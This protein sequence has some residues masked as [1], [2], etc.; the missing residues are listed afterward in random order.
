MTD[1][2]H[3][4][5]ETLAARIGQESEPTDW[6]EITQERINQFAEATLDHQWIHTDPERAKAGPF[7]AP[8]A[9]G[10]LSMSI[11]SF[12]PGGSG[13]GIPA[14]D[15]V[16]L[17]INYG[18]NKVRFPSPVPVGAKVRT[19]S[20]L[21]SAEIKGNMLEVVNELTLEVKDSPKPA[22]VAESVLRLVF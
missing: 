6:F 19:R 17:G 14:L 21:L 18:W 11:M 4:A 2:I 16:K 9:H 15:G 20:K 1:A 12:L 5:Q 3:K 13:V 22:C 8:I 7:G 10:Q